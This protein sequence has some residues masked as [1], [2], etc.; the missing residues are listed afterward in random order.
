[1][2]PTNDGVTGAGSMTPTAEGVSPGHGHPASVGRDRPRRPTRI[3]RIGAV[4]IALVVV[5]SMVTKTANAVSTTDSRRAE[6]GIARWELDGAYYSCLTHQ[7]EGLVPPDRGVWVSV[8]SANGSSVDITLKEIVA[9]YAPLTFRRTGHVDLSL[10]H[11]PRGTGCLGVR[12][13]AVSADGAVRYGKGLLVS[14]VRL[15][16]LEH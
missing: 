5:V 14:A 2:A 10:V 11:A 8:R 3:E 7:V 9:G 15:P 1:M 6:G 13:K 4:V 16:G 12:V